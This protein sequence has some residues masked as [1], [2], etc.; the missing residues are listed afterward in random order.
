MYLL[1]CKESFEAPAWIMIPLSESAIDIAVFNG[2]IQAFLKKDVCDTQE[3]FDLVW[4]T[5]QSY[6]DVISQVLS[7]ISSV[8]VM[9]EDFL[10]SIQF[11]IF[12]RLK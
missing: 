6:E 9:S 11:A 3:D 7:K 8:E 2:C 5:K 1:N 4:Q 12:T 10:K